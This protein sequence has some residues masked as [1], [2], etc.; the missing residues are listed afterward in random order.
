[1]AT[2][3]TA[4]IIPWAGRSTGVPTSWLL[5]GGEAVSRTTYAAL[6]A[7]IGTTYGAGDGS[8]TFNVPNLITRFPR[9]NATPGGTGGTLSHTH[10]GPPHPHT[11]TQAADH[12]THANQGSHTHDSHTVANNTSTLAATTAVVT[13]PA[14]HAANSNHTH[15]GSA[16]SHASA[17][18][19]SGTPAASDT[20]NPPFI[21]LHHIIRT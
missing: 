15:T 8:T 17:A 4:D 11:I 20:N 18:A 2:P 16:H 14:T 13:A 12:S 9:G 5:C 3:Q 7:A 21:S 6:F 10:T 19:D 1:M